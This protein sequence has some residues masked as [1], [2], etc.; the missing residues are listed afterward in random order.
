MERSFRVTF[1]DGER[2][3]FFAD[4]DEQKDAW[5]EVLR[6]IVERKAPPCP[7]W[8]QLAFEMARSA[9]GAPSV[10]RKQSILPQGAGPGAGRA[11]NGAL[12]RSATRESTRM[13]QRQSRNAPPTVEEEARTPERASQTAT[14]PNPSS[15]APRPSSMLRPANSFAPGSNGAGAHSPARKPVPGSQLPVAHQPHHPQP[16]QQQHPQ[17]QATA[18]QPH[19]TE[20]RR[21]QPARSPSTDAL[22]DR[23]RRHGAQSSQSG[24]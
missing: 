1:A 15:S 8:A 11:S 5:I 17:M 13:M 18:P 14:L 16:Q 21:Y 3:S 20:L 6:G 4:T 2:I 23:A 7:L 22:R 19:H 10:P 9:S 24:R 12:T